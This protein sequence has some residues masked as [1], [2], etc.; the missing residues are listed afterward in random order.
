MILLVAAFFWRFFLLGQIPLPGDFV[1][2]VYYPWLD[3]KWGYSV[4][5]PVKN[6]ITADVVSFT[7]PMRILAVE[8][9][10]KGSAPLW[11]PYILTGI[12]LMA[13]FQSAPFSPTIFLYFLFNNLDA[14]SLQVIVQ[15]VLVAIFTYILL[16]YWKISE[17]GSVIGGLI[18]AFSG[19]NLIWSQW[20]VHA[21]AASFI[22]LLILFTAKFM[23]GGGW[24]YGL[25]L[26][27]S[28]FFQIL[29]GYPQ[30]VFYTFIAMGLFWLIDFSKS[31]MFLVRTIFL[32]LFVIL[33]IGL[34][35]FQILPA[36]ELL[37]QSQRTVE[38]LEQSW[39][40]LPLEK[41]ITFIAPDYFGNHVTKNYWGPTDYTTTTGYIGVVAIIL[42][43][44]N[45][46]K[47]WDKK[48]FFAFLLFV[49][50]L[51]LAFQTPISLLIWKSGIFGFQAA[52][53]HR[54]LVL[55]T[56]TISLLAA[57]GFDKLNSFRSFSRGVFLIP[58]LLIAPFLL[59]SFISLFFPE[60]FTIFGLKII[61]E[62]KLV[63]SLRNLILPCTVLVSV[64]VLFLLANRR[65]LEPN[66]VKGLLA[67][68]LVFEL[69]RFGWKFTPFVPKN[70]VY[71][72]TPVL[73]F[74][75]SQ[76]KPFR[77]TSTNVIPL[78]MKMAY[79]LES[80]EGYDAI[81]P[82]SIA[83]FIAIMNSEKPEAAPQGRYGSVTNLASPLLSLTN[84]KYLLAL[85]KDEYNKPKI[86]G[87]LEPWFLDMKHFE[88][89]FEDKTTVVLENKKVMPRAFMVYDW[90]IVSDEKKSLSLLFD[91]D[92]PLD[93]KVVMEK[94]P[95]I[96]PSGE[97]FDNSV[98]YSA[99]K[100]TESA[101]NV[102]TPSPGLLFVS[103]LFYPGWKVFVDGEE[104]KIY[105]ADYAFR[106][107]VI[108][109]GL[110]EV[111]FKYKPD[112]FRN[113]I[114]LS[115]LS[116][117]ALGILAGFGKKSVSK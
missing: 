66:I 28:L 84:T 14:W 42:A 82:V 8:M 70:I 23:S 63:V 115:I 72:S 107:V 112:S 105:R 86:T 53:S 71:P 103:D 16:R 101:I 114:F 40:F 116:V 78:N 73:D 74:L 80:L 50:S 29:S 7:Y 46:K 21:L 33:G 15:H 89:V 87:K 113:G 97:K 110:H 61:E 57:F 58:A 68:I 45:V 111:V 36:R 20:N 69:F 39:A 98:S 12:P 3:Y 59:Y 25:G 81:Y 96:K 65:R 44:L 67:L 75:T 30:I 62:W 26:S 2:G 34:A 91:K 88:P 104:K 5:V 117:F 19:F 92:F 56:F 64:F 22:P 94:D 27:L 93:K 109:E 95:E 52:S 100:E 9:L 54:A 99:Y 10:R 31:K 6:P 18:F 37:I 43:L 48:V 76:A 49:I 47:R 60:A 24:K 90:E 1:V 51:I 41:I 38:P 17:A 32:G 55:T 77:V 83:K 108:P 11:N 79:F 4:G 35:S 106:A 13:N 85:K 102:N